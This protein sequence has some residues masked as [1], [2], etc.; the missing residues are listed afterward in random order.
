MSNVS[1]ED[2]HKLVDYLVKHHMMEPKDIA[3]VL[4]LNLKQFI[5]QYMT[6]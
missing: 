3:K 1:Y 5:E 6:K 4:G 2:L